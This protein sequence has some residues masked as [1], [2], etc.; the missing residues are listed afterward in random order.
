MHSA[1]F[2]SKTLR[3][4]ILPDVGIDGSGCFTGKA[5]RHLPG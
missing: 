3:R 4:Q 1:D 2:S 5:E